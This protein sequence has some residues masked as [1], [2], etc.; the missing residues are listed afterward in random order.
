[1]KKY[2]LITAACVALACAGAPCGEV[3]LVA[4]G[5]PAADIVISAYPSMSV[6][7]AALDLREHLEKMSGA[8]LD[9]VS[10]PS[11]KFKNHVFV[12]TSEETRKLNFK[13]AVFT[14]SGFEVVARDNY[15][16][17]AGPDIL[18]K[19][20]R[21]MGPEGLKLWHE[22]CGEPFNYGR[23]EEGMGGFVPGL[24][25]FT[26]DDPGTW[27]AAAEMLEQLGVRFYAP[28]DNG[29]VIPEKKT[30]SVAGQHLK[31]EAAF[32]RR[33]FCYYN[34]MRRDPEGIMWFKRIKQGNNNI[35]VY[36]HTTDDVFGPREIQNKHPEFL[37]YDAKG[38]PISGYP[39]GHGMP[40]FSDPGFRK[41]AALYMNKRFEAVPEMTAMSISPPDGGLYMD[42]RDISL[43]GKPDDTMAQKTANYIWDFNV[44]LAKELKKAHPDKFLLYGSSG[45]GRG[46]PS[47]ME[48]FPDNMIVPFAQTYSAYRVLESNDL[49]V[50]NG[51]KEW[52]AKMKTIRKGPIWDYFL[53]YRTSDRP[54]Y[55]VFFTAHLQ[56]EVQ[57]MLPYSDGKFIEIQPEYYMAE[58]D[59]NPRSRLG[60]HGLIHL[61]VYWHSKLFWDP[62]IDRKAMLEEYYGLF[63]GPA[64]GEMKEFHEFAEAVWCRQDSR[65]VTADSG[66]LKEKDVD[67]YFEILQ[68]ARQRAGKD[69]VYDR[70]IAQME[71][72]M[73]S[74]KKLFPNLKRSGPEFRA[75][76]AREQVVVDGDLEKPLWT[77][78]SAWHTMG[79]PATGEIPDKNQTR[80]AFR[81]TAD[82][83]MIVFAAICMESRMDKLSSSAKGND[84][85]A[86][87]SDDSVHIFLAT[88]ERSYF[89]IAANA[90]G[91][92]WD[93][94]RDPTIVARDTLPNLW[95]PGVKAVAK[96][97][98]DRWLVELSIPAADFGTLGPARPY[99]WGINV[100]R[101]RTAGGEPEDFSLVPGVTAGAEG[102]PALGNLWVRY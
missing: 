11:E 50:I 55:P 59:K 75:Y 92:I 53:Y 44:F 98:K 56:K 35:I 3:D 100:C 18:R 8:K 45:T 82:K 24:Q 95:N 19:A 58:G 86:I 6:R 94:S 66:F 51:R 23:G 88:P 85:P 38:K 2:R 62:F 41:A 28:Y 5:R 32:A 37:A 49:A 77:K 54:R 74:L 73:A 21:F 26:N 48:E 17:L 90:D 67:R 101:H 25:M 69:T 7:W 87:L 40:R 16:I 12:G 42:A 96:K 102:L 70:R 65:S 27:Y 52:F 34:A 29:T 47:N 1:M 36:N 39:A 46:V 72:E 78:V 93:E 15:I 13:P 10:A 99:M 43:Y 91:K 31:K 76:L 71:N 80:V 83:S 84:D 20:S 61:M 4:Q 60:N 33:E 14:N 64:R 81:W 79:D 22:F 68:R 30:I 97:E 9:I 89:K 57:E 63:F